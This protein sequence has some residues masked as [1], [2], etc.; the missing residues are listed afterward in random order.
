MI[1][2]QSKLVIALK[3]RSLSCLVT[4]GMHL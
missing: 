1:K 4:F 3:S 2:T